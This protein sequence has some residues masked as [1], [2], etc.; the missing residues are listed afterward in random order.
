M[1]A[2][3]MTDVDIYFGLFDLQRDEH[4][5]WPLYRSAEAIRILKEK[6]A[7]YGGLYSISHFLRAFAELKREGAIRQVRA[8]DP[9]KVEAQFRLTADEYFKM[10][11]NEIVRRYRDTSQPEFRAEVDRLIREGQI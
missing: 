3:N 10:P 8:T 5:N 11:A 4:G 2:T 1:T 6:A 7:T 9:L